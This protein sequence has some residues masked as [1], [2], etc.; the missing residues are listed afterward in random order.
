MVGVYGMVHYSTQQRMREFGIRSATT[1][2]GMALLWYRW[3]VP[4]TEPSPRANSRS[5]AENAWAA[6]RELLDRQLSPL[7]LRAM[8]ALDPKPG[9]RV[10]DVGC[11]AGQT[12]VQLA[13]AVGP[14][15]EV[16][17]IDIAPLLLE[18][19]RER[20]ATHANVSFIEGDAQTSCLQAESFDAIFSRFGVMAF[21]DPV[22][23]FGNLHQALKPA[24]RL[25][26]V[27]WRSLTENELDLLP[28]RAAGLEGAVDMTP[29]AFEDPARVRGVLRAAG[30][31]EIAVE[32]HEQNVGS[33]GLEAML[34][35]VMTVGP[36][37]KILRE[38]PSLR[39]HR[40]FG[41]GRGVGVSNLTTSSSTPRNQSG[42]GAACCARDQP[43]A[44]RQAR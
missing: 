29:F 44:T 6:V 22:E 8:A 28:L 43:R 32:P 3:P 21:G 23:A 40:G 30:F 10:L 42:G 35:V 1:F 2:T 31:D 17:G 24:G 13:E 36:L 27:C 37:G 11:G 39:G 14:A 20:A 4:H 5:L 7:G 12:V 18:I 26:F 9:E 34:S 16:V 33:G 19:A 41:W 25:A 15:G 38:A